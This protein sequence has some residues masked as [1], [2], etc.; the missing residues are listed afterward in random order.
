[1]HASLACLNTR[2]TAL[3]GTK[4]TF[5]LAYNGKMEI[6]RA[7]TSNSVE[8]LPKT[9]N[10]Y[11]ENFDRILHGLPSKKNDSILFQRTCLKPWCFHLRCALSGK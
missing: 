11:L 6:N 10:C 8:N 5:A 7:K 9:R 4:T 3:F 2:P 1:M